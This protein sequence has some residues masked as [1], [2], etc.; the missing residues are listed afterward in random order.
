[1]IPHESISISFWKF[2]FFLFEKE[3]KKERKKEKIGFV[4]DWSEQ[5]NEVIERLVLS[6]LM[7][8]GVWERW[9]WWWE[10]RNKMRTRSKMKYDF[11]KENKKKRERETR[12]KEKMEKRWRWRQLFLPI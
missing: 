8:W 10:K 6:V 7:F 11:Q 3:R 4:D 2:L 5:G 9:W 1:M 12:E